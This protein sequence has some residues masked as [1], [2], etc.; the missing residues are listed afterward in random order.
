MTDH[1]PRD[2][3]ALPQNPGWTTAMRTLDA[4]LVVGP[5]RYTR[6]EAAE[7]LGIPAESAR[8]I[9]QSLGF[10]HVP[11]GEKVFTAADLES[12]EVILSLVRRGVLTEATAG[13][14]A[15]SI[16]QMTDRMVV[17]Q[18]EALVEDRVASGMSDPEARR[19]VVD[20]LPELITPL[21]KAMQTV[22]RRQLNNAV[23]RLT[24]NVEA[25]LAA[26]E[27]GR[28]GS[29]DDAPLPLA[30]AVG[31]ADM[32]SYTSMS[33]TMDERTLAR[34]VQRF[35]ARAADII[36]AEGGWLVKTIGD[37]VLFNAETPEVGARIALHL[38]RAMSEDPVLPAARVALTWG[39]VLSRLGDIYGPTVNLAARLTVLADPGT[40]LVDSL[41][42]AA[43]ARDDRFVLVPQPPQIV[44]GFGEIR[45]SM[46]LAASA[47]GLDFD[48]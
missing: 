14:L 1:M 30:R 28:D 4:G 10:S 47:D 7:R 45:P 21:E 48:R 31:F 39:R 35:E 42:A 9:W 41:T 27:R 34:M 3:D 32:V 22:Y 26:S 25:G 24:V 13:S 29:E 33:R 5:R 12:F 2:R 37:E 17:W 6:E 43:L 19:E 18:I 46:L 36:T 11:E 23:Q 44:R 15:R 20:M 8:P 16:G 40:V 38:A